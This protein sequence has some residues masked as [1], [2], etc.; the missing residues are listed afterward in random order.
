MTAQLALH[1]F[2]NF[3]FEHFLGFFVAFFAQ[4]DFLSTHSALVVAGLSKPWAKHRSKSDP[5]PLSRSGLQ[6]RLSFV[7]VLTQVAAAKEESAA[8]SW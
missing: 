8:P 3:F 6:I 2:R 7:S 1:F 5:Q 4:F